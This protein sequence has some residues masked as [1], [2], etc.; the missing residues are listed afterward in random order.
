MAVGKDKVGNGWILMERMNGDLRNLIDRGVRYVGYVDDGQMHYV[1][2][3][4][5]PFDY[6]DTVKMLMDIAR[7]WRTCT[8]AD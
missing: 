8:V 7:G 4:E 6:S 3:G 2:P 5:M 1:K